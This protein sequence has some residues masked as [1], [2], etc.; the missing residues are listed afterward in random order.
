[1][2]GF[3]KRS[4]FRRN[5]KGH[6]K[7]LKSKGPVRKLSV[8]LIRTYKQI[9]EI[10]Y[11][12]KKEKQERRYKEKRINTGH[13]SEIQKREQKE[14][15]ALKKREKIEQQGVQ[16]NATGQNNDGYDDA[17]HDYIIQAGEIWRCG[18]E[19][20]RVDSLIGKGS[21]GQVSI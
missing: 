17:N 6:A 1:M 14:K 9:N 5:P 4:E 8:E 7:N 10:Y 21:F 15:E 11:K 13:Q 12:R 19:Q 2:A 3:L 16:H 18:D 20:Y